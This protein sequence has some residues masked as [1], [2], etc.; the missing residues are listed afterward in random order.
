MAGQDARDRGKEEAA[1]LACLPRRVVPE[2][3][4]LGGWREENRATVDDDDRGVV[5]AFDLSQVCCFRAVW[6]FSD[7]LRFRALCCSVLRR[8]GSRPW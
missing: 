7:A 5:I 4:P 1:R 3:A 2:S 8:P 6:A